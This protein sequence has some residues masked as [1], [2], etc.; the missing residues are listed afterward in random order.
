MAGSVNA[1]AT[2]LRQFS[3]PEPGA[4]MSPESYFGGALA[5]TGSAW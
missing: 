3:L 2:G 1:P 5:S 4:P